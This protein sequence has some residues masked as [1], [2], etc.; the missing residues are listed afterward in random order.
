MKKIF[1]FILILLISGC[2]KSK[3]VSYT[4]IDSG[5]VITAK[6]IPTA[7]NDSSKMQIETT[8]GIYIIRGLIS[9]T[10]GELAFVRNKDN[11]LNFL[12]LETKSYCIRMY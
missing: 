4:D 9:V 1:L 6:V 2:G 8:N 3:P 12:C 7:F 5:V 10:K 11:G